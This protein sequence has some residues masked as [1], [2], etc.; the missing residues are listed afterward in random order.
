MEIYIVNIVNIVNIVGYCN[1][2]RWLVVM[3]CCRIVQAPLLVPT[4]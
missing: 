1:L 4:V 2:S 3:G